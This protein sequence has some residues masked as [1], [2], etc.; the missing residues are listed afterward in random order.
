MANT[1]NDNEIVENDQDTGNI[2]ETKIYFPR[3]LF[4]NAV[5]GSMS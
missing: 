5:D 2:D 4:H 3:I 1:I